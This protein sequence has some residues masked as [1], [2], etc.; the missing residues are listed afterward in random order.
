MD[1]APAPLIDRREFLAAAVAASLGTMR[2]RTVAFSRLDGVV[3]ARTLHPTGSPSAAESF[4]TLVLGD[5]FAW[6]PGLR[7]SEKSCTLVMQHCVD[8]SDGRFSAGTMRIFARS[9][10][11]MGDRVAAKD[12][13]TTRDDDVPW[14]G[15]VPDVYWDDPHPHGNRRAAAPSIWRQLAR[16]VSPAGRGYVDPRLVRLVLITA[17]A[18]D[19]VMANV[20]APRGSDQHPSFRRWIATQ[21]GA[22]MTPL[23]PA[24][25]D[26]FPNARIVVAGYPQMVSE[27]TDAM[28]LAKYLAALGVTATGTVVESGGV[29]PTKALAALAAPAL[30]TLSARQSALFA[31]ESSKVLHGAVDGVNA[32]RPT[33]RVTFADVRGRWTAQN[34]Y[35]APESYFWHF[36]APHDPPDHTAAARNAVCRTHTQVAGTPLDIVCV[37]A[38]MGHPNVEGARVYASAI[39]AALDR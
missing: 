18:S 26:A 27:Q 33:K 21:C 35:G 19:V 25:A 30:K 38:A 37:H 28:E 4:H 14:P 10:S 13:L 8:H 3:G 16:A 6:Q 20:V 11:V 15:E 2:K 36:T 31:E 39:V 5:S 23:L 9:G 17:G 32:G 34:A 24:V 12:L 22:R 29:L 7:T 1:P